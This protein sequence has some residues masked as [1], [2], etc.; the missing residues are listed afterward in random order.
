MSKNLQNVRYG[1]ER[2]LNCFY[3]RDK[4]PAISVAVKPKLWFHGGKV[5]DTTREA[6]RYAEKVLGDDHS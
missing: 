6:I 4:W 1:L 5:D 3:E 2:L